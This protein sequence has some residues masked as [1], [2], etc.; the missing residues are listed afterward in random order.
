MSVRRL[1]SL[2]EP[3]YDLVVTDDE[4]AR[5]R[6]RAQWPGALTSL[7]NQSDAAIV[8]HGTPGER[9][10]MVWRVTLDAWASSGRPIP[11]YSRAN[12]PGRL[13]R[14]DDV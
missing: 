3:R 12:M 11:S 4:D 5:R 13:T 7:G 9:I 8:R 14:C 2:A 1:A 6:A 10:A